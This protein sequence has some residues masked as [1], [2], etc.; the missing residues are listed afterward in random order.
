MKHR[1]EPGG[2]REAGRGSERGHKRAK[3][4][5]AIKKKKV[6]IEESEN[7]NTSMRTRT[8]NPNML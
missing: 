6:T 4:G 3:H 5:N 7:T 8:R 1:E 2:R